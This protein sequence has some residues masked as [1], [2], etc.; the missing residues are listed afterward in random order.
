[1]CRLSYRWKEER[2]VLDEQ[3][4]EDGW[5]N[6]GGE[7]FERLENHNKVDKKRKRRF[8]PISLQRELLFMKSVHMQHETLWRRTL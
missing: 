5:K 2:S 7:D 1:M 3:V 8:H 4:R 6:G